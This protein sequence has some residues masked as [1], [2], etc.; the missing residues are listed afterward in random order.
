MIESIFDPWKEVD[1]SGYLQKLKQALKHGGK[2]S[3]AY[4]D[5]NL[6]GV[7][8][9][10]GTRI[11]SKKQYLELLL[12]KTYDVKKEKYLTQEL[13]YLCND[14]AIMYNAHKLYMIKEQGD[15]V[16]D[17]Y[18]KLGC[19]RAKELVLESPDEMNIDVH[20]EYTL[21]PRY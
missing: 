8:A 12:L 17:R 9:L 3:A 5:E 20:M 2:V 7:A 19:V 18:K 14:A 21:S 13:F 16:I 4:R 1:T 6:S 10:D 11:G 15:P